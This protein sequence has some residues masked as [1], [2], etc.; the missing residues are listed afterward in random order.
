MLKESLKY[1]RLR[2]SMVR[3][4][5]ESR[6][7]TDPK[8]EDDRNTCRCVAPAVVQSIEYFVARQFLRQDR[9]ASA[10][11]KMEN[12]MVSFLHALGVTWMTVMAI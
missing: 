6:G 10:S 7:I 1:E 8:V 9:H 3:E 12:V 4:Q 2:D 11:T 5:I